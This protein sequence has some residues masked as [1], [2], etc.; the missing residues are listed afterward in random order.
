M[1][2]YFY[3][4]LV[5]HVLLIR[6]SHIDKNNTDIFITYSGHSDLE[7]PIPEP[8]LPVSGKPITEE[9]KESVKEITVYEDTTEG[10]VFI[11]N[12]KPVFRNEDIFHSD[13]VHI[14]DVM[15]SRRVGSSVRGGEIRITETEAPK[16]DVLFVSGKNKENIEKPAQYDK[17]QERQDSTVIKKTKINK[18]R[19]N[20]TNINCN[21]TVNSVCGGKEENK[22]MKYRLFLNDCFFRK[23][24]CGFQNA[25]NRYEIVP[26]E[27]C[28]DIGAHY[29]TRPYV[30]KPKPLPAQKEVANVETRR[31]F[32]S[33][34][35]LNMGVDGSFCGHAC[36]ASCTEDYD[37]Q[38]AV[39]SSGQRRMFLNH[40]KL[41]HNSCMYKVVWHRRPLS[42]CVGGR[43][44]DMTQNRGFIGWMQRVGIVDRKG[45]LMLS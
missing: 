2:Y 8:V 43:K 26:I 44:A 23:V 45:R 28:K 9:K 1:K 5:K 19:L 29:L 14:S 30:F 18:N 21:N 25:V 27:N 4:I 11:P 32:S 16:T 15:D 35:S 6:C 24:N 41:D 39:S 34:R 36:P 12:D 7:R 22:K 38:C 42:E 33:R 10:V 3:F 40:C 20:C 37:P 31:S 13:G 17:K